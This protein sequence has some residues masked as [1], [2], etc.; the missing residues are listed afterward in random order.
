MRELAAEDVGEDFGVPVIVRGEAG[1]GSDAVFVQDA[2][3]TEGGVL[4]GVIGREGE[5]MVGIQPSMVCVAALGGGARGDLGVGKGG[6]AT[7]VCGGRHNCSCVEF[8]WE[9]RFRDRRRFEESCGRLE[10]AHQCAFV[11]Y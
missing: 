3:A 8:R 6:D 1:A 4:R 5:G 7:A 11:E 2:Q 10:K 9:T